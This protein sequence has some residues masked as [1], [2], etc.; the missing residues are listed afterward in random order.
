MNIKVLKRDKSIE[1]YSSEKIMRVV[2]A[3]GLTQKEAR[4]LTAS[5]TKWLKKQPRP[6][7]TSLQIRDRVLIEIQ[8][9]NVAAA[10]K[11]IWFEKYKDKHYGVDI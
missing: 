7:I 1:D 5:I 4:Q 11:F 2:K 9:I 6:K 3:A 8:K 10:K